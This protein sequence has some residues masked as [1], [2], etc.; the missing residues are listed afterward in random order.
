MMRFP[1]LGR[2]RSALATAGAITAVIA[3]VAG[4]AVASGGYASE[5]VDLGDASVWVANAHDEAV[6]RANTAVLELNSVVETGGSSAEVVQ[7]GSTVLVFDPDRANVGSS[8]RPPPRSPRPWRCRPKTPP[9]PS[10]A[11]A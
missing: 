4:V 11:I 5:R 1:R 8:T 3:V 9:S 10:P 6:G 2:H 7:Q